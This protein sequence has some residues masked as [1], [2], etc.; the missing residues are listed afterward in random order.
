[1]KR[2]KIKNF[3]FVVAVLLLL[4]NS[5]FLARNIKL[6]YLPG[7]TTP[8][9][10]AREG[11]LSSLNYTES[12]A[13]DL[14]VDKTYAVREAISKYRYEVF[15]AENMEELAAAIAE[16]GI[17]LRVIMQ[18]EFQRLTE[19]DVLALLNEHKVLLPENANFLIASLPG[20]RIKI[21]DEVKFLVADIAK[22]LTEKISPLGI[23]QTM[24]VIIEDQKPFIITPRTFAARL[25][26]LE[27]MVIELQNELELIQIEAGYKPLIGEG[28]VI[29]L[30]D[31]DGGYRNEHI[32][33]DTDIQ[34]VVNDLF[35]AGALGLEIGGQ[36]LINTSSIRCAGPTILVNHRPITVNPITIK[37]VGQPLIL[38]GALEMIQ[39]ELKAFGVRLEIEEMEL[40]ALTK[41]AR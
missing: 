12:L 16:Q 10:N 1:M 40:L 7:E 15:A 30:F 21:L 31:A 9:A 13:L 2:N 3:F 29:R 23:S 41:Y 4:L 26:F 25:D 39:N 37:A 8:V 28:I 27:N 20:G 11:A 36:R 14:G 35:A 34:R 6:F 33:H 5:V 17:E 38:K 22:L 32:V 24:E 19:E 18:E